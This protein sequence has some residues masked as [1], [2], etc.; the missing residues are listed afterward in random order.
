MTDPERRSIVRL[1]RSHA[2]DPEGLPEIEIGR[3]LVAAQS[4]RSAIVA[5]VIV[6]IAYS[7]L[8]SLFSL[9]ME[10]VFPWLS[11][12]LGVL[13]GL[14]VR[15]AGLGLDW[16]FP[17][18]AVVA[19]LSGIVA[20]KAV[21][22]AVFTAG[23]LSMEAFAL[24]FGGSSD[25][26]WSGFFSEVMTPAD[27]IFAVFAAAIAAFFSLRRLNRRQYLALRL[28]QQSG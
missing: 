20:G 4:L 15:R 27:L 12:L 16:R 17:V 8:W 24:L 28:W 18:C 21:I 3:R 14:A 9:A 5:A 26:D 11:L 7:L 19:T 1:T 25:V 22:A 23:G 2:P 10:K 13:I 6:M